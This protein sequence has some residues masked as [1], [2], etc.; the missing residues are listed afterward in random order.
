M[1]GKYRL[2]ADYP[3]HIADAEMDDLIAKFNTAVGEWQQRHHD[4]GGHD[5]AVR[6][7][8]WQ[9]VC[10]RFGAFGIP[11]LPLPVTKPDSAI[12]DDPPPRTEPEPAP[13]PTPVTPS[14]PEASVAPGILLFIWGLTKGRLWAKV[15]FAVVFIIAATFYFKDQ[16]L[17]EEGKQQEPPVT[18]PAPLPPAPITDPDEPPPNWEKMSDEELAKLG[19]KRITRAEFDKLILPDTVVVVKG[20]QSA[21]GYRVAYT[22]D[23]WAFLEDL[24]DQ[25]HYLAMR[26]AMLERKQVPTPMPETKHEPI[27]EPKPVDPKPPEPVGPVVRPRPKVQ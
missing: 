24:G 6:D 15:L 2:Y 4:G 11:H 27:P 16:R 26:F 17:A 8:V 3:W 22:E 14:K 7:A 1:Q 12:G 13:T 5:T 20:N 25:H 19:F 18:Q 9:A 23:D 21:P 10:R